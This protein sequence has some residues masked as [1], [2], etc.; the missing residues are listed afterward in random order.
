ML[1]NNRRCDYKNCNNN[2]IYEFT[3]A[4]LANKKIKT[5]TI[6]HSCNDHYINIKGEQ[7]NNAQ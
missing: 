7:Q 3:D 2:A 6:G 5:I 1:N 4:I